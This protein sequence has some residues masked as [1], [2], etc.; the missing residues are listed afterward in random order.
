MASHPTLDRLE[1]ALQVL[2]DGWRQDW[3]GLPAV[4]EGCLVELG[5]SLAPRVPRRA[6]LLHQATM[7]TALWLE[8]DGAQ[9]AR[10]GTEP[11]YHNR[12]HT[13]D[14]LVALATLLR[15]QRS[16]ERHAP[17]LPTPAERL[18]LLAMAAHDLLHD[19]N[20]NR[21]GSE[22]ESRSADHLQPL[23]TEMKI[24]PVDAQRVRALILATDPARV[25]EIHA[26]VCGRSF[27]VEDDDCLAVLL[28]EAD[29]LASTLV[30]TG[31]P[32][33]AQL[34]VE[35]DRVAPERAQALR[36][37]LG[38]LGFLEHAALFSS[39]AS[40]L[41]GLPAVRQAQIDALRAAR[42]G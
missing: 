10:H 9:R 40:T 41:L 37:P 18:G 8:Q 39:P 23:L 30:T 42:G 38:R 31:L 3:P 6:K 22:L 5:G 29:I 36:Q 19:G 4:V 14:T 28:V 34:A 15:A 11:A 25:P 17:A 7:A 32:L 12:L 2:R 16:L 33:T 27:C 21:F 1:Q 26:R 13:A 20:I 24:T 35:W